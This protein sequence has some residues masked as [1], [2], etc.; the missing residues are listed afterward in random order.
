MDKYSVL[1]EKFGFDA[2][3]PGQEE[4]IDAVMDTTQKGILIVAS[5]GFGKSVLYQVPALL[6]GGL[7]IVIS[8]LI[9]LMQDQVQALQAKG[10]RAEFYNSALNE[11]EKRRIL[12]ELNFGIIELLYISPE[13]FEDE[14]FIN[15][16]SSCD[17]SLFAIDECHCISQYGDF[18]PA[19]RRLK[20]A[21]AVI[22]PKQ[23]MALTATATQRTQQDICEQLGFV[24]PRKF[25]RGF[26]RDNL[27]M[28]IVQCDDVFNRVID[29]VCYFQEKGDKTGIVYTGT[30]KDAEALGQMFNDDHGI[31]TLVYHAGLGDK[32]RKEIQ[33]E[34]IKNG[35]NIIATNSLGMGVDVPNVRYVFHTG[36][37]GSIEDL[38]QQW[39]RAGRDFFSSSCK[40]YTNV[41]KD[42]WLQ[43]FFINTSCPPH[44]TLKKFW[45]WLNA[46][47]AKNETIE[48][49]QEKMAD[50][51][52][53]EGS[54]VGGC[55]AALKAAGITD[56]ISRGKYSVTHY[57]N[58]NDAPINYK[59]LEEKRKIKT[60]KLK[61]MTNF[62]N[63]T[64]KCRQLVL[65]DYFN[66][67]SRTEKCK[68]CDNCL[69]KK[70][71]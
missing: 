16:L 63:N 3:R 6:F 2:F 20:K 50:R 48:M 25:I 30:R 57:K 38:S 64:Y 11:E 27:A 34:W 31:K 15:I 52:G 45:E 39:G 12:S 65:M 32:E 62:V 60:D 33:E 29:E 44:A 46:L 10:V 54:L 43:N 47:A 42:L 22:K 4:I 14:N 66:D 61:E 28:E 59:L 8:P 19:Y 70:N 9:S 41:R 67:T 7:N 17:V 71:I 1:K 40:L 18:R 55:M 69:G 51:A 13:R 24:T 21:I 36:M 49:T 5:T 58:S 35:G 56:T 23:V 26:Y 37:P 68:K 53:I